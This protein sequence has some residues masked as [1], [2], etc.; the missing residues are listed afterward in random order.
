MSTLEQS[1]RHPCV[2]AV[3]EPPSHPTLAT[4]ERELIAPLILIRSQDGAGQDVG[5]AAKTGPPIY[6]I[7]TK[8]TP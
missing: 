6:G 2:G 7:I 1:N 3:R 5:Y 4:G 8:I